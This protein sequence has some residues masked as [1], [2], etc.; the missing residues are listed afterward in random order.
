MSVREIDDDEF[1]QATIQEKNITKAM[2]E[3]IVEAEFSKLTLRACEV[4]N[5]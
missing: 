4:V 5:G 1:F 2:K 3:A